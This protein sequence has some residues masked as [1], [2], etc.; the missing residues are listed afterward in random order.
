MTAAGSA[1]HA[2]GC[3][4]ARLST[5]I[6]AALIEAA[7]QHE[8]QHTYSL[9]YCS[10]CR[11]YLL[12]V[13][14]ACLKHVELRLKARGHKLVHLDVPPVK[15]QPAHAVLDVGLP[16]HLRVAAP[17]AL[18]DREHQQALSWYV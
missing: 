6:E 12:G 10:T 1:G 4:A 2:Q 5:C 16:P 17:G 9:Q 7:W 11:A 15:L 13:L 8:Y 14:R 3:A 18:S